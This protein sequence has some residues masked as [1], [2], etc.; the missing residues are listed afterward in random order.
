MENYKNIWNSLIHR[1]KWMEAKIVREEFLASQP[2]THAILSSLPIPFKYAGAFAMIPSN[3]DYE[4]HLEE[5]PL[6]DY[7]FVEMPNGKIKSVNRN[8]MEQAYFDKDRLMYIVGLI[9]SIPAKNKDS[10]TEDGFVLINS[11]LLRNFFKDYKSYIDYLIQTNVI[12]TDGLYISGN[13]SLGYKFTD[14]YNNSSL[15][16]YSYN[17]ISLA[18]IPAINNDVFCDEKGDFVENQVMEYPYLYHWYDTKLLQILSEQAIQYAYSDKERKLRLG[19]E[20]WD[21]NRDKSRE[22]NIVRKNPTTQ[23]YAAMHN[24]AELDIHH[25]NVQIDN[26]VHRLHSVITN[27]Q[28]RYRQFLR[29]DGMP[30][31]GVDISN[32]QPYLLCML[33]NPLFWEHNIHFNLW[34][35]PHNTQLYFNVRKISEIKTYLSNLQDADLRDYLTKASEG[36]VY[37]YMAETINNKHNR[38]LSRD[39]V[40]TMMMTVLFSDNRHLPE[41]KRLFM[42]N[43]PAI[44]ELI[45][46]IKRGNHRALACLLQNIESEIILHRCCKRIWY[47]YNQ[48]IPVFTI[49][50]SICTTQ[51]NVNVVVNIMTEELGNAI[52]LAPHLTIEVC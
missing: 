7:L 33:L 31:V 25:Y 42:Y 44:Y 52:G 10:I 29:Y 22:G 28:K 47:E 32:C 30:L 5:Y 51:E 13:K 18:D 15:V 8:G 34:N 38:N 37:E 24:I 26:N 50:D 4:R 6:T 40:K 1:D 14:Q 20:H 49:H 2:K 46:I 36:Q 41:L 23:Y 45:K 35:L 21:I 3:W 27:I 39:E 11:R 48:A 19:R 43:F 17:N 9:S 12:I 16:R